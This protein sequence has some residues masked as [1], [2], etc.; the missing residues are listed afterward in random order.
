MT[1]A[2]RFEWLW[3]QGPWLK[4]GKKHAQRH[5][6]A[7]VKTEQDWTAIQRARE[8]YQAYLDATP[9]MH[10]KH[11]STW[12]NQWQDWTEFD[13]PQKRKDQKEMA[14]AIARPEFT[15][16]ELAEMQR[17]VEELRRGL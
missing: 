15:A 13:I 17:E 4:L 1:T 5:F 3:S 7:S 14:H 11:G 9:W 2:E 8:Q 12:F 6:A 10:P 16:E